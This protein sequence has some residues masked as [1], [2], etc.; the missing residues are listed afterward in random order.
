MLRQHQFTKVELVSITTPEESR[1]EHERMLACAEEVLRRLDLHYRVVTLCTG[2]MGFAAQKTYDIE[3]WLPG[4]NA[5]R[6]ISS[7]SVCGEFQ[8]RRMN[9]RYRGKESRQPRYVSHPQRLGRRRRPR[10]HR[11]HGDVPAAG[12]LDRRAGRAAGLH[13]WAQ[14]H[15]ARQV[16]HAHP[17][18]QRRRHPLGGTR[19]LHRDRPRIV[20]RRLG[21]GAG[22]RPVGRLALALAQRSA[23]AARGR[24]AP[25]RGQGHAHGLR[26]HGRAP[27]HQGPP[28]RPGAVR[29][30]PRPQRGR[31]RDL[32]R[33][34]RRSGGGHHPRH[35]L[36]CAVAVH[37]SRS[38][39][40]PHWET[41]IRFAPDI[42]RRVL[43]AGIP[44]DVLINVN[45][46]D[47][48]RPR[49]RAS[50]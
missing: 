39:R 6:E 49:S 9:A 10:A 23:A 44:R 8:A 36:A 20:R 42:I 25:L 15:R 38:G 12:W 32:F 28:A 21:A 33:H 41:A 2:D 48:R 14:D 26:H 35:S 13:G 19:H 1:D 22:V 16:A 18:D 17:G 4:Q 47:C 29:R 5:Y 45:F 37:R 24:R 31:G 11:C 40:P 3:V 27:R 30:Q 7:C 46:P 43:A 50:R 34:R